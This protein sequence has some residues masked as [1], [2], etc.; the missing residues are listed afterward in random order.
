MG[1]SKQ[2]QLEEMDRISREEYDEDG[3][4]KTLDDMSGI[5]S[6]DTSAEEEEMKKLGGGKKDG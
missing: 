3:N 1:V 4:P 5:P 2:M 6:R